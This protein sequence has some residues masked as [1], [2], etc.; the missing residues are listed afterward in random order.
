M[1]DSFNEEQINAPAK[2]VL[3]DAACLT[4]QGR[5]FTGIDAENQQHVRFRV[6]E[7]IEI[8]QFR[9]LV[10]SRF[11]DGAPALVKGGDTVRFDL[12]SA[13]DG[14]MVLMS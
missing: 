9:K 1:G 12:D 3:V 13:D 8:D 5:R 11:D 6:D 10:D 4:G 14:Y 2:Q 7:D